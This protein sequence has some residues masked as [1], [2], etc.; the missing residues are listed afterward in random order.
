MSTTILH[1]PIIN[2]LHILINVSSYWGYNLNFE[3]IREY[4]PGLLLFFFDTKVKYDCGEKKT[5]LST[6]KECIIP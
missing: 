3:V 6:V 4:Q 2:H 1:K 5:Y